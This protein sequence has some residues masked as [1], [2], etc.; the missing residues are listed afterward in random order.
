MRFRL[1]RNLRLSPRAQRRLEYYGATT[2]NIVTYPVRLVFALLK[3]FARTIAQWWESRNLRFLLQGLP[4]VFLAIAVVVMAAVMFF[5][6]KALLASNVYRPQA[7][8]SRAE[9]VQAAG[10]SKDAKAAIAM[11]QTCLKRLSLL[12]PDNDDNTYAMAE[13]YLIQRQPQAAE[14]IF[15]ALAPLPKAPGDKVKSYGPAHLMMARQALA[16]RPPTAA[17][18]DTAQLHLY[19]AVAWKTEPVTSEAHAMLFDLLRLRNQPEQAE[20]HLVAAVSRAG[21]RR[22]DWRFVLARWYMSQGKKD[23]ATAQAERAAKAFR[24]QLEENLDNHAARRGLVDC[25]LFTGDLA[26]ARDLCQQGITL[27][28]NTE[29]GNQYRLMLGRVLVL[30]YDARTADTKSTPEERFRMLEQAMRVNPDDMGLLQRLVGFTRQ[31]GELA[32]KAKKHFNDLIDAQGPGAAI[33]H[34]MLG[35][36]FWQQGDQPSARYHWEKAYQISQAQGVTA[37]WAL[38]GNNLA[39]LVA[40]SKP[41]DLEKGLGLINAVLEKEQSPKFFGT[42]G[43]I[44]A[45]MGR[46]REAVE[47]LEK[48]K[49]AYPNDPNLFEQLAESCA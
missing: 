34:M 20:Q 11:A 47:D 28:P 8:K 6:D 2:R 43:H 35:M 39:W 7:F 31:S 42:R 29:L 25:L 48:A 17:S 21:D 1:F 5:Q 27:V 13:T 3:A 41:P 30:M 10:A 26:G 46:H 4:S 9:A 36:D 44:L 22:P 40:F 18:L 19:R 14:E 23:Q 45:K 32:E 37:V 33:A 12:Q 24:E 15:K 38:V 16:Q 49:S